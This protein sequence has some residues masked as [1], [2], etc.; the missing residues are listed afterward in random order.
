MVSLS[1][2]YLPRYT[3][4]LRKSWFLF[5]NEFSR[6]LKFASSSRPKLL[7]HNSLF[8]F[9]CYTPTF[10]C[11]SVYLGSRLQTSFCHEFWHQKI[12]FVRIYCNNRMQLHTVPLHLPS[13]LRPVWKGLYS[14]IL[15][16]NVCHSWNLLHHITPLH[17]IFVTVGSKLQC[18]QKKL[19]NVYKSCP[20][21]ISLEK[22]KILTPFQKLPESVGDLG[23]LIVAKGFENL[24]KFQ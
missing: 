4:S 16:G 19:P 12:K 20:K 11:C 1:P 7:P 17:H 18:D 2:S 14:T 8:L 3:L 23:K 22:I 5:F 15:T 21:M 10:T 24:P 6:P 13:G 9:L